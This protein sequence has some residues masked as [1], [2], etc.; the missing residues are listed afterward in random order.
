MATSIW[1]IPGWMRAKEPE[2]GVIPALTEAFNNSTV[3]FKAWDG[4]STMWP[5]AVEAADREAWRFA[6][7]LAT[8]PKEEREELTIV[9]HSLGGRILVRV[10]AILA[11]RGLRIRQGILLAAAIPYEDEDLA[12][13]GAGSKFPVVAICNPDDVTLRYIY[14]IAG[15]EKSAAFGANGTLRSIDNV[16]E[17]VVPKDITSQVEI[18]RRW[19]KAILLISTSDSFSYSS[20]FSFSYS[21]SSC[22]QLLF[23]L[24]SKSIWFFCFSKKQ[25]LFLLS[26]ESGCFFGRPPCLPAAERFSESSSAFSAER[27]IA[28]L[29][30]GKMKRSLPLHSVSVS[31]NAYSQMA[32]NRRPR[33]SSV[34]CSMYSSELR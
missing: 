4:N 27:S 25:L 33:S 3:E 34:S 6:F 20:S 21:Y 29:Y 5:S 23:L 12:K 2:R 19:A 15:G 7:E 1:Y 22:L 13:I 26:S 11:R 24:F 31:L 16:I 10:L 30:A 18:E 17:R 28:A 8:M 9:G 14:A 32:L